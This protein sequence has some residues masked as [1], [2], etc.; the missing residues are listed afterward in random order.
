MN[1]FEAQIPRKFRRIGHAIALRI[2]GRIAK[3]VPAIGQAVRIGGAG[4]IANARVQVATV[5]AQ[6]EVWR[7]PARQ[8][9]FGPVELRGRPIHGPNYTSIH[10][11]KLDVLEIVVEGSRVEYQLSVEHFRFQTALI[12]VDRKRTRLN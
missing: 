7:D 10:A 2:K 12:R 9:Y 5:R 4:E 6:R 1:I 8:F 3:I 11:L